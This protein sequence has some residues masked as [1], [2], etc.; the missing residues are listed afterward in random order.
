M[1]SR[2]S[3]ALADQ[4]YGVR[5]AAERYRREHPDERIVGAAAT[6]GIR[7]EGA[8]PVERGV[9]WVTAR[10]APL[11]VTDRRIVCGDW[12]L[13]ISDVVQAELLTLRA[14]VSSGA[15]LKVA[16][17][18]GRHYQFGMTDASAWSVELPFPVQ[19]T[20][21]RVQWSWASIAWRVVWFGVAAYF[22]GR[23]CHVW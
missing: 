19:R 17:C 9:P 2:W 21:G 5:G 18:D 14:W 12:D 16:T 6:K 23:A 3:S 4:M 22:L 13:P 11:I 10:R 15:I 20:E 8:R 1:L 7:T